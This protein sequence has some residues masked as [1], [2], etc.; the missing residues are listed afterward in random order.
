MRKL[1]TFVCPALIALASPRASLA[2]QSTKDLV[3]YAL[4]LKQACDDLEKYKNAFDYAAGLADDLKSKKD[5]RKPKAFE[6]NKADDRFVQIRKQ[7]HDLKV[8]SAI[9]PKS[10]EYQMPELKKND[11]KAWKEATPK[12]IAYNRA[13]REQ[14]GAMEQMEKRLREAE[15]TANVVR[16]A[17]DRLASA[18]EK[19]HD[20][21]AVRAI[22]RD[23]F[24]LAW[25][26]LQLKIIP[27]LADIRT[28][29]QSR[30]RAFRDEREK[31]QRLL[32]NHTSLLQAGAKVA[33]VTLPSDIRD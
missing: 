32:G 8:P 10:P 7:V 20:N 6:F 4:K 16:K 28:E 26:D 25:V 9:D 3:A 29:A 5:P 19:L 14:I 22:F 27:A 23:M 33:G 1:I 30:Q 31:R 17:T 11:A 2:E 15:E 13:M 12:L 18:L 24:G 21:P